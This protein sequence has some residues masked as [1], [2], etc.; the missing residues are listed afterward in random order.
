MELETTKRA[1]A[2]RLGKDVYDIMTPTRPAVKPSSTGARR[3]AA[4]AFALVAFAA[5]GVSAWY[6]RQR[7]LREHPP[8]LAGVIA[9]IPPDQLALI[10][11][12]FPIVRQTILH[13][14]PEQDAQLDDLWQNP[15]RSLDEVIRYEQRTNEILT[16]EQLKLY[17]PLRKAMQ[18]RVI[19]QM[20]SP[21]KDRMTNTDYDKLRDEVNNR[22]NKRIDGF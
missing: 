21:A 17:Q 12:G 2:S 18:R 1:P 10:R 19:D 20:L 16:T 11:K 14:T 22:V 15:P 9:P 7:Y 4:I 6:G 13:T 3:T 8:P 5:L